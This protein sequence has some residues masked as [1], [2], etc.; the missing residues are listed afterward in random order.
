MPSVFKPMIFAY[1]NKILFQF[2]KNLT[3]ELILG[4]NGLYKVR[5]SHAKAFP[6]TQVHISYQFK[7]SPKQVVYKDYSH[8][9]KC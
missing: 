3:L 2:K 1:F 9:K 5:L 6:S 4:T 8:I 7:P